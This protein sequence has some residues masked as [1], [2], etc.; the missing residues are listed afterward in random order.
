MKPRRLWCVAV[1]TS[2]EAEDAIAELLGTLFSQAPTSYTDADSGVVAVSVY[3]PSRPVRFLSAVATGIASIKNAG[4][5]VSPGTVSVRQLKS[6]DWAQSWKRHFKPLQIGRTLLIKPSWSRRRPRRGQAMVV[7]DPGLSFGTGQHPTTAF[8]L[9]RL[10]T[11]CEPA[12]TQSF[13]DI[14]TGS[15]ILAISAAKLGYAPVEAFDLDPDAVRIAKTNARRN[16]VHN[17]L[18]IRRE[19]LTRLRRSAGRRFHLICANLIT[20]LLIAERRRILA[21][22]RQ[23]GMLVIAGVLKQEFAAVLAAYES[24]GLKLVAGRTEGEWKSAA[25]VFDSR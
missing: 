12:T 11:F 14:G 24:S 25:F 1:T 19:D 10:V 7:L 18:H 15:G 23:D 9:E 8:C 6:Q 2:V 20:P 21:R 3:L 22:L 5:K 17:K 4:L 16:R 13:L